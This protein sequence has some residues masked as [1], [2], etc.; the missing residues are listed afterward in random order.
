MKTSSRDRRS[1][2]IRLLI[3]SASPFIVLCGII[4]VFYLV[5]RVGLV[6][7]PAVVVGESII[8]PG[9][10]QPQVCSEEDN[11]RPRDPAPLISGSYQQR[12]S[13]ESKA[14]ANL[15]ANPSLAKDPD[16]QVK[17]YGY[18]N[19]DKDT[20]E[21]VQES[22]TQFL[23]VKS[24]RQHSDDQPAWLMTPVTLMPR[25]TYAY[26]FSYRSNVPIRVTLELEKRDGGPLEYRNV[27]TLLESKEWKSFSAHIDSGEHIESVRAIATPIKSGFVDT[28][29][30]S[31]RPIPGAE[32]RRGVVSVTF[33]DGVGSVKSEA[34]PILSKYQIR[35]TQYVM[36]DIANQNAVSYMN[37][38]M[39]KDLKKMGHEIGSHSLT[40]CNQAALEKPQIEENAKKTKE[41]LERHDLGP[42]RSFTYPFGRYDS[43]TQDVYSKEYQYIRTSDAGY[44]DRYFD[45]ANI[46]S[47]SVLDSTSDK[48]FSQWLDYA[49]ANHLWIV[50]V[51]H[52][53]NE[54]GT[55]NVTSQQLDRQMSMVAESGLRVLPLS[56]AAD[57]VRSEAPRPASTQQTVPA[58]LPRTGTAVWDASIIGLLTASVAY[59][60]AS[61]RA[62]VKGRLPVAVVKR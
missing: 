61:R 21:S 31:V 58:E 34:V 51:Y 53:V 12:V 29:T 1:L 32:L 42:V 3:G 35:S 37:I 10:T 48:T 22:D 17:G 60:T 11:I 16:G 45:E 18:S 14:A 24:T 52:R 20:Y 41:M 4:A 62:L 50:L 19:D 15:V 39:L 40:H 44:N 8:R 55:Y 25:Q 28:K 33:D 7:F 5:Y 27:T 47:M 30:Y 57:A 13:E 46:R 49:K 43:M 59:W 26:S 2:V 6:A 9:Q 23:R 56:E 38:P 54:S 36:G